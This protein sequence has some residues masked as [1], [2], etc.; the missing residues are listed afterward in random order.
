M[1]QKCGNFTFRRALLFQLNSAYVELRPYTVSW[2]RYVYFDCQTFSL[3]QG[4]HHSYEEGNDVHN[5]D[6][7]VDKDGVGSD[8]DG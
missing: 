6:N 2:A 1:L 7:N 3:M 8:S 4:L 5:D